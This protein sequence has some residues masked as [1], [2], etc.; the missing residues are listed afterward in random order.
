MAPSNTAAWLTS[1]KSTPLKVDTAPY[2]SP[3]SNELVI[4]A[5]AVAINP[6]DWAMQSMG[7]ALFPLLKYPHI[8]GH[9]VAG[10]VVEVGS[11]ITYFKP[12]DRVLAFATNG[13]FQELVIGPGN[14]TC[15]IPDSLAYEK[16][17]V[18]PLGLLT[19]AYGL[20]MKD[21]LNLQHPT[22]PPQAKSGETLVIWGASTSVGCN[23]IQ[24]AVA[25]GYEVFA[26]A[27]EKNFDFVKG[28]GATEVWDYKSP[29][30]T[31]DII[32]AL[33]GK[34]CAGA[35]SVGHVSTP[36]HAVSAEDACLDIVHQSHGHKLVAM[37][38]RVPEKLPEGVTAKFI[39]SN[40][41]DNEVREAIYGNFLPKALKEGKY[42]CAPEPMVVGKGLESV[43]E[44]LDVQKKGVSA[45]KVVVTL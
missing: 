5:H 35:L 32:A 37:A 43:Q 26:T 38:L 3:S 15:A 21:Y 33:K 7:N 24:L 13:G 31:A 22:S 41:M 4:R 28:L 36:E 40:E 14:L 9:D 11:S 1:E 16:A 17:C 25:S 45:R 27:G 30:A 2:Q 12:G 39:L 10:E 18:L 23:A 19:A 44:A 20:Y 42:V 34:T 6:V 8:L 29:T